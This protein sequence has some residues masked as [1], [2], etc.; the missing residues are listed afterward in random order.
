MAEETTPQ[1]NIRQEYNT[2]TVGLNLDQSVN[3][4]KPGTLTYALNANVENFD[5]SSVNY[6]NEQGNEFCVSFPEG[7]QL[8]GK[9]F[10]QEQNKHIFFLVNT[11]VTTGGSEIGYM[12]NNDCVYRTLVNAPCLNFQVN[13]PIHKVV[14]K[15]TN[16]TTEIYWTDGFNP[17]RY[18]DINPENIP[19][20]LAPGSDLCDPEYTTELDCNRI[21]VQPNFDIPQLKITDVVVGGELKAGT[22]QFAIQYC[23][24]SGNPF[25]SFY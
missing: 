7:Y 1:G 5:A 9:Y 15:I 14:H 12:I 3:Q 17:R 21:K 8:I 19:Y 22:V 18:L 16:C 10:I 13:S 24:S 23:D 2:A 11:S 6:Q 25:T 20:K 4:I